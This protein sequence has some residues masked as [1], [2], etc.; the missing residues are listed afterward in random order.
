MWSNGRIDGYEFQV[1]HFENGSEYGI[2][3]GRVSKL[4]IR[5]DGILLVNYDRG[6]DK[7]PKD[8][9]VKAVYEIILKRYN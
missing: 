4:E 3:E 6:W 9:E 2:E 5:K 1:K 8:A 7:K